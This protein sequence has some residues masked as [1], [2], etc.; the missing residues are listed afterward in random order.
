MYIQA[1]FQIYIYYAFKCVLFVVVVFNF[2]L[3]CFVVVVDKTCKTYVKFSITAR[4]FRISKQNPSN[5]TVPLTTVLVT[6]GYSCEN[7]TSVH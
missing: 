3:F 4:A 5:L 2:F 1:I 6:K 7:T